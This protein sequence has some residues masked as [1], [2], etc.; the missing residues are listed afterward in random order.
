[1]KWQTP[2]VVVGVGIA[3]VVALLLWDLD[4]GVL[5]SWLIALPVVISLIFFLAVFRARGKSRFFVLAL[6]CGYGLAS[7]AMLRQPAQ[8][9][10]EVRWLVSS[11]R[12]KEKVL[13]REPSLGLGLKC[14]VWDGWGMAG[15][16]TE[17]Y[18]VNSPDDGLRGY[19][20]SNLSGLPMQVW[21]IQRLEKNWYSVTFYTNE[22]WDGCGIE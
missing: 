20:P 14:V 13:Q 5:A 1:M 7:W 11:P 9:R 12:W 6:L 22:R 18:L 15:Q 8:V 4:F 17:V 16:D 3:A 21:R 10:S 19:T 2:V